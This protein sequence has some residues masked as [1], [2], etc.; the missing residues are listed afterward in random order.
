M[1][2]GRHL[3]QDVLTRRRTTTRPTRT[4]DWAPHTSHHLSPSDIQRRDLL[5]DLLVVLG[6]LQHNSPLLAPQPGDPA[7]AVARGLAP[8]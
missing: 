7:E 8:D 2:E 1:R 5:D 6:L 4:P 3:L